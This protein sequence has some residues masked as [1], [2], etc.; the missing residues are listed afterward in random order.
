M[1]VKVLENQLDK[2]YNPMNKP[3][4]ENKRLRDSINV[5]RKEQK[6]QQRV[7]NNYSKEMKGIEDKAL[8][9]NNVTYNGQRMSDELNN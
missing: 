4:S 5:M 7:N 2:N 1:Q 9:L 3:Q 8:K 6:N